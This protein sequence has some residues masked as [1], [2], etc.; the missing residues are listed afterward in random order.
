MRE[1][2]NVKELQEL[3]GLGYQSAMKIID[4]VR[5]KMIVKGYYIPQ[6][7]SK[8]ALKWLVKK[9]LGIKWLKLKKC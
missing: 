4:N 2:I 5:A 3:T 7:K 6:S 9:E 1:Y 8:V